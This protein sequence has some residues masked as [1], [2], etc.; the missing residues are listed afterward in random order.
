MRDRR[1]GCVPLML[2]VAALAYWPGM[3]EAQLRHGSTLTTAAGLS[4]GMY[5]GSVLGLLGTMMP[6]NRTLVGGRCTASGASAGGAVALA[7]GGL[8]G[9]QNTGDLRDRAESAGW[10][11]LAGG[12]VG[13]V[14][15]S[16][17]R[18]Y[19]WSDALAFAAVGGAI[20][21]ASDGAW[22]GGAAGLAVGSLAWLVVPKA[23]LPEAVML[24]LA[25]VAAGGLVDWAKG[26]GDA[27]RIGTTSVGANFSVPIG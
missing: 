7:M 11:A 5:S 6:C 2:A 3:G 18:Q 22:V 9:A 14:M 1:R 25:G 26:A 24:T 15:R 12:V 13:V 8:I 20:G 17:V 4:L 10:G 21:A 27:N 19:Q 23:G 16:A